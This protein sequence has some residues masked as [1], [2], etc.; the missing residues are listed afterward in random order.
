MQGIQ[1]PVE[2]LFLIE[3]IGAAPGVSAGFALQ[4][5]HNGDE[6]GINLHFRSVQGQESDKK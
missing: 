2:A 5:H 6:E 3:R 4:R 1:N